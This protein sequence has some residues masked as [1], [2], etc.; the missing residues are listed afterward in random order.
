[1]QRG[2][3][4]M[5]HRHS[6]K[7]MERDQWARFEAPFLNFQPQWV[8]L[9]LLGYW[10]GSS[11]Q[12]WIS[13]LDHRRGCVCTMTDWRVFIGCCLADRLCRCCQLF[14]LAFY[15]SHSKLT[16]FPLFDLSRSARS[17]LERVAWRVFYR[18]LDNFPHPWVDSKTDGAHSPAFL[19]WESLNWQCWDWRVS[20]RWKKLAIKISFIH[21]T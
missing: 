7:Q 16:W 3:L 13:Q 19:H 14:H 8:W 4:I 9:F 21:F 2:L 1:M 5:F 12:Y 6:E 20:A 15:L 17:P 11:T 18:D 10:E